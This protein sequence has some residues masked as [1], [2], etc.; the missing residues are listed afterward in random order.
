M[1]S[2]RKIG[3]G[4]HEKFL[5]TTRQ[6]RSSRQTES[7]KDDAARVIQVYVTSYDTKVRRVLYQIIDESCLGSSIYAGGI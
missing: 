4:S 3:E 6:N 7:R 5:A 2:G 1:F